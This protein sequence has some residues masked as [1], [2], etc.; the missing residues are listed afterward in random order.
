MELWIVHVSALGTSHV[1]WTS[2]PY[3]EKGSKLI[4]Q[5]NPVNIA[6]LDVCKANDKTKNED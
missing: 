6:Y 5:E 2:F 3:F 1:K 4:N